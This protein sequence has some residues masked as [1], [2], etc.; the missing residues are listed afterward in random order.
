[1]F[2]IGLLIG[3]VVGMIPAI[4]IAVVATRR[5]DEADLRLRN[6]RDFISE[7]IREC[8]RLSQEN[9]RLLNS[10]GVP[11]PSIEKGAAL[12]ESRTR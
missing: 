3:F 4:I 7:V 11:K 2:Y 5:L 1:M 8:G 9:D 10:P 12:Y 6:Q